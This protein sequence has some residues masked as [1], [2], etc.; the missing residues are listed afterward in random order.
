MPSLLAAHRAITMASPMYFRPEHEPSDAELDAEIEA[1]DKWRANVAAFG[2]TEAER[3]REV[4]R[5]KERVKRMREFPE[6]VIPV[7]IDG[8]KKLVVPLVNIEY[9]FDQFM[10]LANRVANA[11][12]EHLEGGRAS[13]VSERG[14]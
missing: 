8:Q 5:F 9:D 14:E 12:L 7:E 2:A 6:R 10:A 4:F 3:Y 1:S 13:A 11:L